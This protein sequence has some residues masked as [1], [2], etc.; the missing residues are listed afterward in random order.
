MIKLNVPGM[1]ANPAEYMS[2]IVASS[3]IVPLMSA[4]LQRRSSPPQAN[5]RRSSVTPS[6]T[7]GSLEI[8]PDLNS[9]KISILLGKHQKRRRPAWLLRT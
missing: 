3:S 2:V 5:G 6:E 8:F 7:A 9:N 4:G 1:A